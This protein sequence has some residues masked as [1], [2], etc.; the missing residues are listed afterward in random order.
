MNI[1]QSAT[2]GSILLIT[3]IFVLF[4]IFRKSTEKND[5]FWIFVLGAAGWIIA[6]LLRMLPI[7]L[8][9]GN[10][11]NVLLQGFFFALFAGIF[12]EIIRFTIIILYK[13]IQ[14]DKKQGPLIL[15]LGW[16]SA[17][18]A[19]LFFFIVLPG[20]TE[21][22]IPWTLASLFLVE[23]LIVSFFHI[24]MSFIVFS[25]IYEKWPWKL[26]LYLAIVLH[27]T[28]DFL[29]PLWENVFFSELLVS[30]II[31]Y[32]WSLE[33][34]FLFITMVVVLFTIFIWIP[35]SSRKAHSIE[36]SKIFIA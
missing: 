18:I 3:I 11:Q 16:T 30:N 27:F 35:Y 23:R 19:Y 14:K 6:L 15:G 17:E 20:L 31:L 1:I 10:I 28:I 29:I 34:A 21:D 32:Y 22:F 25:S 4:L 26:G 7:N 5:L 24:A 8:V 9:A 2:L 33:L 36:N 12:E 13:P